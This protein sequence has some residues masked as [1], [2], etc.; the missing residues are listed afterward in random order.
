MKIPKFS[1]FPE[2]LQGCSSDSQ[3][4]GKNRKELPRFSFFPLD[5]FF[6]FLGIS[7]LLCEAP[8]P[9]RQKFRG[10][11][12]RKRRRGSGEHPDWG[13]E[14]FSLIIRISL[15][16][17]PSFGNYLKV[18]F[19]YLQLGFF[20]LSGS[21]ISDSRREGHLRDVAKCSQLCSYPLGKDKNSFI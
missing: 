12:C 6:L 19:F 11:N 4:P 7:L 15:L 8:R 20:V 2:N 18:T 3:I 14:N 10:Q 21:N 1:S 16:W 13:V 17:R 9:K 5:F